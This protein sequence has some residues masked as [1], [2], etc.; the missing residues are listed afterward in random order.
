VTT[1]TNEFFGIPADDTRFNLVAA[2]DAYEWVMAHPDEARFVVSKA[3]FD[4]VPADIEYHRPIIDAAV[5][6]YVSKRIEDAK[7]GIS[8]TFISKSEK[9]ED[10]ST[11]GTAVMVI[12]AISKAYTTTQR[13]QNVRLQTRGPQGRWTVMNRPIR[14]DV[15]EQMIPQTLAEQNGVPATRLTGETARRFQNDYRE[16]GNILNDALR[17]NGGN[18]QDMYVVAT[19]ENGTTE[20]IPFVQAQAQQNDLTNASTGVARYSKY[21]G[22]GSSPVASVEVLN[23]PPNTA[24]PAF[25]FL[26]G[27]S[28]PRFADHAIGTAQWASQNSDDIVNGLVGGAGVDDYRTNDQ[29]WRRMGTASQIAAQVGGPYLP[30]AAT[31]ALQAGRWVGDLAPEAE[32]VIGPAARK[33]AYRY[34]GTEKKPSEIWQHSINGLRVKHE[35]RP[36]SGRMAH[37]EMLTGHKPGTSEYQPS[38]L[39]NAMNN[40]LPDPQRYHLNRKAGIIPPSQGI[41][42]DRKG[43]VVTEAVGYG[44]DWYLPFNLKN[45][46]KLDGG[47]YIRTRAFGGPTT[48]DVYAGLVSGARAV[49]VVSHS[50][51]F[52]IEFDDTFRGGRRYNDKAGR[53]QQRY[54]SLLDAVKSK[55]VSMGTIPADRDEELKQKAAESY[56]PTTDTEDYEH[57]LR[58]LRT[59]ER[60]SPSLSVEQKEKIRQGLLNEYATEKGSPNWEAMLYKIRQTDPAKAD[61]FAENSESAIRELGLERS[62][63]KEYLDNISVYKEEIKPLDLNGKGYHQALLSLQDQFPYYIKEIHYAPAIGSV[64]AGGKDYGYVK[65]KFTRP[66]GALAGYYDKTITGH[67]RV[68]ADNTDYQNVGVMSQP[69]FNNPPNTPR[70]F[71]AAPQG[72]DTAPPSTP[73]NRA[74]T[75]TSA[76]RPMAAVDDL[77]DEIEFLRSQTHFAS[78][79]PA[80]NSNAALAGVPIDDTMRADLVQQNPD[81]A[82]LTDPTVIEQLYVAGPGSPYV[83]GMRAAVNT[84][85]QS[86]LFNAM[87][88]RRPTAAGARQQVPTEINAVLAMT[89]AIQNG[90]MYDIR[91]VPPNKDHRY[92][93]S[94]IRDL[95][96]HSRPLRDAGISEASANDAIVRAAADRANLLRQAQRAYNRGEQHIIPEA[97]IGNEALLMAQVAQAAK[98]RAAVQPDPAVAASMGIPPQAPFVSAPSREGA[99]QEPAAAP[100][101]DE[102]YLREQRVADIQNQIHSMVGMGSVGTQVDHLVNF[103]KNKKRREDAGL[104]VS[105][106]TRHLVFLGNPGTGKTTIAEKLAPIYYELGLT[107]KDTFYDPPRAALVSDH[108]GGTAKNIERAFEKAKGGVLFI[109]EAYA[110][111][112]GKHDPY[113]QE[114]TTAILVNAEKHKNDT[115]VILAGYPEEMAAFM[116]TNPGLESRFPTRLNFPNFSVKEL[117]T[118]AVRSLKDADYDLGRGTL[119]LLKSAAVKIHANPAS[120][121]ARDIRNLFDKTLEAQ[122]TRLSKNPDP[123]VEELRQI[124]SEDVRMAMT[125]LGNP[126]PR[127]PKY[128]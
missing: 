107:K 4:H 79:I 14:P 26:S 68:T 110:L 32:K 103:V 80:S 81:W 16:V 25:D 104:K 108:V 34:R 98:L 1:Y 86:G 67:G 116:K 119:P 127:R 76:P 19:H 94:K 58:E 69:E 128:S 123:S 92:Y 111:N 61:E 93:T 11:S 89:G 46:S 78:T 23:D 106:G 85:R 100:V 87:P 45:L 90:A 5:E 3:L 50:G 121:N 41:I 114:A 8:R 40:L 65:P 96:T 49:T 21:V 91:E 20:R 125:A 112:G 71:F 122:A 54:G 6:S 48:E 30:P 18:A 44:E 28:D 64:N 113:G 7:R 13:Q 120:G 36:E 101:E 22:P 29:F 83:T 60:Q 35:G 55:T 57:T 73:R 53:M 77:A 82:F 105:D 70:E 117:E 75:P 10:T 84:A 62:Y 126:P 12:D 115:V 74:A 9:G 43:Q 15:L 31:F 33:S 24:G 51:V 97:S 38:P 37:R 63:Q 47:E 66:E 88:P 17:A 27:M 39:I 59:E 56:N 52:T 124:K 99:A 109:D 102:E 2:V 42:I 118:I 95:L 72:E